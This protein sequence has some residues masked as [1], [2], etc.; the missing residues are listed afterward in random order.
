MGVI[1]CPTCSLVQNAQETR[2]LKFDMPCPRC[3]AREAF[4]PFSVPKR[5]PNPQPLTPEQQ[6]ILDAVPMLEGRRH[7]FSGGP[8]AL[9]NLPRATTAASTTPAAAPTALQLAALE[10]LLADV[11]PEPIGKWMR[12][13]G[14]P[15]ETSLA[16][17]PETMRGQLPFW[18]EYVRFSVHVGA[19]TLVQNVL[20]GPWVRY[21]K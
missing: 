4:G 12:E 11:P 20:A 8:A 5:D 14:F 21:R 1:R 7:T 17:L 2:L 15:P 13:Q 16:I 6:A 19:P 18:P 3:G 9:H 10:K